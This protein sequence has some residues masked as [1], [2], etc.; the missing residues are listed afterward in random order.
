MTVDLLASCGLPKPSLRVDEVKRTAEKYPAIAL[1]AAAIIS[2]DPPK[3]L[4][5]ENVNP[6]TPAVETQ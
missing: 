2:T 1:L 5:Q 6:F 4:E 3:T